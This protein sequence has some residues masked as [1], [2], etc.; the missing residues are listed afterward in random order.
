MAN[1]VTVQGLRTRDD[2]LTCEKVEIKI[3]PLVDWRSPNDPD[4]AGV[5]IDLVTEDFDY[6]FAVSVGMLRTLIDMHEQAQRET[7]EQIRRE[8]QH[9]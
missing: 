8:R 5:C 1:S 2:F 4:V 9:G 7:D 6:E 3:R